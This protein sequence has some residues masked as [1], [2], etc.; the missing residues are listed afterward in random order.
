MRPSGV[1]SHLWCGGKG[2]ASD[3]K[4]EE[5]EKD[6]DNIQVVAIGPSQPMVELV[7]SSYCLM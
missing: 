5:H 7:I 1:H 4:K 2:M 3:E 6:L